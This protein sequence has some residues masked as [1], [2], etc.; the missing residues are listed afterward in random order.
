MLALKHADEIDWYEMAEIEDPFFAKFV[1]SDNFHQSGDG[2]HYA[3]EHIWGLEDIVERCVCDGTRR[4]EA[5]LEQM[6]EALISGRVLLLRPDPSNPLMRWEKADN[7]LGGQWLKNAGMDC[8]LNTRIDSL[9]SQV[10]SSQRRCAAVDA[11]SQQAE[12]IDIIDRDADNGTQE[13]L[14][15]ASSP[16]PGKRKREN[17][18]DYNSKRG[19]KGEDQPMSDAGNII[20][21][22]ESGEQTACI[23]SIAIIDSKDN[24]R[25][26]RQ[27]ATQ[28]VNLTQA[29]KWVDKTLVT[30]KY[31]CS[32]KLRFKVQFNQP[33]CHNFTV[34]LKADKDNAAYSTEE[35]GENP[36]FKTEAEKKT[37]HTDDNG[38]K[39]IDGDFCTSVAGLDVF[40]LE[41][42]DE[43]RNTVSSG[44]VK[45]QRLVYT[46]AVK[47]KGLTAISPD[48]CPTIEEFAN[49]GIVFSQLEDVEIT[50]MANI[51][52]GSDENTFAAN[53]KAVYNKSTGPSKAPYTVIIAY[54]DHLAVKDPGKIVKS[55]IV[56]VGPGVK[57]IVIPIADDSGNAK[58]LWQGLVPDEGWFVSAS[59]VPNKEAV[60]KKAIAIAEDKCV[61]IPVIA[62]A[63]GKAKK[64]QID[65]TALPP[66]KGIIQLKVNW[67]NRM[68]GGLSFGSN[69]V[70]VCTRA[71]WQDISAKEQN[72]T[73]VHELGH[74]IGMVPDGNKQLD[75]TATQYSGKGHIGS[76]CHKGLSA[77]LDSYSG[78]SGST[79][80]MFGAGNGKLNFCGNCQPAVIKVDLS[81][82]W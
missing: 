7:P 8:F 80:V 25:E 71:W 77:D 76:H 64:V 53:V 35:E 50:H 74:K 47:M 10:T 24:V 65:V 30:D 66:G 29:D 23:E 55:K 13:V 68:R 45:N 72:E 37:Y 82:G 62:S 19:K 34:S 26:T 48:I 43:H 36:N 38:C 22:P 69:L 39:I 28:Y 78:V 31:Q 58:A 20:T 32:S 73:L 5:A 52:A 1:I 4:D 42:T 57:D 81:Y 9:I 27:E 49:Y 75:K 3:T 60:D 51:S 15:T 67:V 63:P 70:C 12:E 56:T 21:E 17:K 6:L 2:R 59:F 61:A 14:A 33:G 41:A 79:C 54:T 40:Y 11:R 18:N 44:K 46:V 16:Q